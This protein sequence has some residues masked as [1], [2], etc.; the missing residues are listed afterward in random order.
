MSVYGSFC[1]LDSDEHGAPI[2]YQGSHVVP[3]ADHPRAGNLDL[4]LIHGWVTA[5]GRSGPADEEALW[6]YLR[7]GAG[8]AQ[9]RQ[10]ELV[11]DV[12]QVEQLHTELGWWLAHVDRCAK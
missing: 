2:A 11:L 1:V 10:V 4:G 12:D 5:Q 3:S 6:P 9:G 8:D 7:V